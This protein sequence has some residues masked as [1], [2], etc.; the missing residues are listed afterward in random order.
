MNSRTHSTLNTVTCTDVVRS[1][2][3]SR[4]PRY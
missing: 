4:A 2:R 3:A 1:W